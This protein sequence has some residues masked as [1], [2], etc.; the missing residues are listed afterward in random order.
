MVPNEKD[1]NKLFQFSLNVFSYGVQKR[2]TGQQTAARLCNSIKKLEP[3]NNI[4]IFF[5]Q[6]TAEIRSNILEHLEFFF[7]VKDIDVSAFFEIF[8]LSPDC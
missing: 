5:F 1:I 4:T 2:F 8:F 7:I 6:I 3:D